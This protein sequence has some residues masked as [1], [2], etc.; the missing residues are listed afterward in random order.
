M[1]TAPRALERALALA[2]SG[3]VLSIQDIKLA[4]RRGV[5][6][7]LNLRDLPERRPR[8]GG[9]DARRVEDMT[10]APDAVGAVNTSREA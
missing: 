9:R 2:K 5:M 4:L 3:N 6:A 1:I 10:E 8:P 7:P